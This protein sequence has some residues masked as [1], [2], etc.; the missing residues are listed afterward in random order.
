M[1]SSLTPRTFRLLCLLLLA[2]ACLR[3]YMVM[4]DMNILLDQGLVQDDA[5]YYYVIAR[6]WLASGSPSFD[7]FTLTNGFH[8][9]WELACLPIFALFHG[10]TP[11]RLMLAIASVC[12]L[13]S[14]WLVFQIV[15][16]LTALEIPALVATAILALHGT[17]IRTWFNGLETALSLTSLL[18]FLSVFLQLYR[19]N[20]SDARQHIKLGVIAALAFLARTD[21]AVV[22]LVMFMFLYLPQLK[23]GQWRQAFCA[24]FPCLLIIAPWLLWNLFHFGSIVQV[25]G[26]IRDN[27]WLFDGAI[28]ERSLLENIYFGI[29]STGFPVGTVFKKMLAP[30]MPG[31]A[32]GY[33]FLAALICTTT[34]AWRHQENFRRALTQLLPWMVGITTLF[35]YHAS[36]RH[37]VRGWYN[38]PVLLGIT[39]LISLLISAILQRRKHLETPVLM[40]L[41]LMLLTFYS[42][43]GYIK[44][45]E[46][47]HPY[48][49][50]IAAHWLNDHV[51]AGTRIGA[52]NAGIMGYYSNNPVINLDGVVN[53]NAF[54]ARLNGELHHYI[55][56]TG[57]TYLAD[58]K[59]TMIHLCRENLYFSCQPVEE[60]G[61]THI[62]AVQPK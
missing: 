39:F 4:L 58:H 17:I 49:G 8:P 47:P 52:A 29:V 16:R 40:G 23:Q 27:T 50:V 9:V 56:S 38:A 41:I 61:D 35:L 18:W 7:G 3:G 6:H 48:P 42:P 14:L 22:L 26:Q 20:T 43:Y 28:P 31:L 55:S 5:F 59:G 12:D 21:S 51:P 30:S 2:A 44:H 15:S 53:E 11:V 37:F 36:V 19:V 10:D 62:V 13:L 33:L 1:T 24:G 45:P 34:I 25:S 60:I 46:S 54:R 57:I 32:I